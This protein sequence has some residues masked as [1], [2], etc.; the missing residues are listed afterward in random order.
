MHASKL[1]SGFS[2][3]FIEIQKKISTQGR[4]L[5]ESIYRY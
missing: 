4:D 2:L 1:V 5:S 3:L